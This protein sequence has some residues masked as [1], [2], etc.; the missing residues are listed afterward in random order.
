MAEGLARG[1]TGQQPRWNEN[2]PAWKDV[3]ITFHPMAIPWDNSSKWFHGDA[4]LTV[5][6]VEVWSEV[7]QVYPGDGERVSAHRTG[8]T[9]SLPRGVLR[10]RVVP[11]RMR[12]GDALMVRRQFYH[13]FFAGGAGFTYGAGPVWAMRG[14]SGDYNCG[15]TWQ[16]ALAFP[17]GRN[18]TSVAASFLRPHRW[19][20][21]K[22]DQSVIVRGAGEREM[23]KA[24]VT[25]ASGDL[26]LV[27]FPNNSH[28][29]VKNTLKRCGDRATWFDP[30]K[31]QRGPGGRL[32]A[33]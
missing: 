25:T 10:I 3:F 33:G 8:Q 4:W 18:L 27:Y 7:D 15:Y 12:V 14:T 23:L 21:W 29:T 26:V 28:A 2:H 9:Q 1:V 5:N 20:E 19:S 13:T 24:A 32:R 31:R 16:Q 6:G 30:R 17:A 11:A 22:P